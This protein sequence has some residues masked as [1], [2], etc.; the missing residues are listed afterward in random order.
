[1]NPLLPV[2]RDCAHQ[3]GKKCSAPTGKII[4]A[5]G[6]GDFLENGIAQTDDSSDIAIKALDFF[7]D[8]PSQQDVFRFGILTVVLFLDQCQAGSPGD[9]L[10]DSQQTTRDLVAIVEHGSNSRCHAKIRRWIDSNF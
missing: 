10:E 9:I 5:F 4:R 6:L 8:E 7:C 3:V 2:F 1:M